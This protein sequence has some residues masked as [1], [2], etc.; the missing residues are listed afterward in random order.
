MKVL[1]MIGV[2]LGLTASLLF[3]AGTFAFLPTALGPASDDSAIAQL[4]F[5]ADC[6]AVFYHARRRVISDR[7]AVRFRAV[8]GRTAYKYSN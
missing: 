7:A 6:R 2:V 3:T 8:A 5:F 4:L 1:N